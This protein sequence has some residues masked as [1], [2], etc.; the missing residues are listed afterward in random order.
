[1]ILR[2]SHAL[3]PILDPITLKDQGTTDMESNPSRYYQASGAVPFV[4]TV[5]MQLFGAVAAA[6]LGLAYAAANVYSPRA[7]LTF[8]ALLVFGAGVGF[9]VNIGAKIGKVRSSGFIML[10]GTAT[11]ILAVYFAW[12]FF[13]FLAFRRAPGAPELWLWRPDHLWKMMQFIA[14]NATGTFSG[15]MLWARWAVEA[16]IVIVLSL[17]ISVAD[18]TPFCDYCNAWTKK[19]DDVASF[20]LA[21]PNPLK[22]E[23]EAENY[24]ILDTLKKE[25]FDPANRLKAILHTCPNCEDSDY[26]TISHAEIVVDGDGNEQTKETE[27]VKQIRIPRDLTIHLRE[28]GE[29]VSF[30]DDEA[31]KPEDE[32][33]F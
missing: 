27:L 13:V 10:L 16:G 23:L 24:E 14:E 7:F 9:A 3:N 22:D 33:E 11:G 6:V 28:L 30:D 12:V 18:D 4:G 31:P 21:D 8:F 25:R 19:E 26:L 15:W 2:F 29:P 5:L 32:M 1:M 17:V 20:P